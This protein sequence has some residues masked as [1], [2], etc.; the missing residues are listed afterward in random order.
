M[1][2]KPDR[3][4]WI[5]CSERMPRDWELVIV[6]GGVAVYGPDKHGKWAWFSKTGSSNGRPI[7]WPVTYWQPLPD[8]PEGI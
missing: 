6:H 2:G 3:N 4:G 8:S 1:N 7:E 5:K